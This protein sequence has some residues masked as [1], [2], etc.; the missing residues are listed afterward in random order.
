[1]VERF[2]GRIV[3]ILPELFALAAVDILVKDHTDG[4]SVV[5]KWDEPGPARF[6]YAEV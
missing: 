4:D 5:V 1:M 3:A 2:Q 6:V